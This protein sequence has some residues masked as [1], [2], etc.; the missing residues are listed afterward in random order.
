MFARY[1]GHHPL[2]HRIFCTGLAKK[3]GTKPGACDSLTPLA[4]ALP[5]RNN[6]LCTRHLT[7]SDGVSVSALSRND[8]TGPHCLNSGTV[9]SVRM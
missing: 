7:L 2:T 8:S 1:A 5:L 6:A 4:P 9:T 3:R